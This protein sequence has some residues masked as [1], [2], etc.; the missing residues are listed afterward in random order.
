M[1]ANREPYAHELDSAGN[2]VVERPASGL[3]SGIEPILRACGGTWIAHGGG[4]AD[5][6]CS[7]PMGRVSVPPEAPEYTLRRLFA[8]LLLVVAARLAWTALRPKAS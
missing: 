1:I 7:D 8:C 4:S 3:V 6:A 5:R 2:V